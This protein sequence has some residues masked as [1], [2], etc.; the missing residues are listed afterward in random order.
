MHAGA[1]NISGPEPFDSSSVGI[2]AG[3]RVKYLGPDCARGSQ[4]TSCVR[5]LKMPHH[6]D[7]SNRFRPCPIP[8]TALRVLHTHEPAKDVVWHCALVPFPAHRHDP[9]HVC[10]GAGHILERYLHLLLLR[11]DPLVTVTLGDNIGP[12]VL[13]HGL[14]HLEIYA[15]DAGLQRLA[16]HPN[17]ADPSDIANFT[18]ICEK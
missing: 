9:E 15:R 12:A 14:Q 16:H 1:G 8:G 17:A 2:R 11:L 13:A 10:H 6:Q 3:K 18:K 4:E 5:N 7:E